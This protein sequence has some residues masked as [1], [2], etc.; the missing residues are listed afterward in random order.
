MLFGK[1]SCYNINIITYLRGDMNMNINELLSKMTLEEKLGQLNQIPPSIV[2]GFDVPFSELIEMVMEGRISQEDFGKMMA[3]SEQDFHE[4]DIK[5]GRISSFIMNNGK[6]YNELQKI[7]VEDS[8]LGIPLIIGFDVIHGFRTIFPIPLALAGMF[9]EDAWENSARIAAKEAM[10]QGIR[11]AFAPMLDISRDARWGRVSESPGEDPYLAGIYGAAM[12]RGYQT[13]DF[14]SCLKHFVGYGACEGG[15]DY[16]SASMSLNTLYNIYLPPFKKACEAGVLTVM[17][18][19]NDLNGIPC[20]T[21]KFLLKDILKEKFNFKGFVVSDANAVVE[22][23]NHGI[24]A[25]KKDAAVKA[26]KAGLDMDM[27]TLSFIE[28]LEEALSEGLVSMEDIDEAVRRILEIKEKIGLFENPYINEEEIDSLEIL[29]KEHLEAARD[30]ARKSI[31]LLKN[32]NVLPLSLDKKI[33]LVGALADIPQE[34]MGS[35]AIAGRGSDCVSIKMA[36]ENSGVDFKYEKCCGVEGDYNEEEIL[37]ATEGSDVIVAVVGELSSMS[38]EASSRSDIKL[39]G[40]QREFLKR[41]LETGKP[42]IACLMNG[43]PLSLD[44]ENENLHGILECW[45]LGTMMG[46]AV[47]DILFGKYNPSGR[48]AVTFPSVTGQCP[49]YY[50]HYNTGRPASKSK[51]TSKY[52]D[53]PNVPE[54]CFGYGLSYTKFDYSD[55]EIVKNDDELSCSITVKNTGEVEGTETVQLYMRDI[56]ASIVRPVKELKGFKKISLKPGDSGR[57]T[58][59]LKINDMGFYNDKGEYCLEEGEFHI[60]MGSNVMDNEKKE[61]FIS[62]VS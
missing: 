47:V 19:F 62:S 2:G 53:A 45:Q 41:L 13:K 44:W 43:R 58:I 59:T 56:S 5:K 6:K 54:F 18:A 21:N 9:D 32:D 7:A 34:T 46:Y 61:I 25:D 36:M 51:F 12:V 35:W 24:A 20:T 52:I 31:V 40:K 55:M 1:N 15:R 49:S 11:W 39:P 27:G 10:T 48:L 28:N 4:E 3:N 42:V 60:F 22:C 33:A 57:V 38:G 50:N 23:V 37:R 30:M 8:R 26:L 16:N 29:P 17:A 14:A